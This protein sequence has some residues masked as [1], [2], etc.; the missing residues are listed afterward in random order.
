MQLSHAQ[1]V[2]EMPGPLSTVII[3]P[4]ESIDVAEID[5]QNA[6]PSY[7]IYSQN[8]TQKH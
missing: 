6:Y 2:T 5:L 8:D 4:K 7:S 3:V 1:S